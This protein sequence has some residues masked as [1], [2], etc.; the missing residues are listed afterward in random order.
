[1]EDTFPYRHVSVSIN[2]SWS[3]VYDF[4]SNGDHFAQWA[5]GLGATFRREGDEWIATGPLGTVNVRVV[6][7]NEFGVA[8]HDVV[9]ET[10][11]TIRNPIRVIPNGAGSTVMFTLFRAPG[12]SEPTFNDD[13][14]T[15]EKD[16][17]ALKATLEKQ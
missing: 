5:S 15:V 16:L 1:M 12:V 7:R 9:L 14:K 13:A 4:V 17:L 2:R 6:K 8:D 10:G 11:L 3:D